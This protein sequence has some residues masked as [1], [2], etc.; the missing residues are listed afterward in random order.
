MKLDR[1][2]IRK[3]LTSYLN[4]IKS[5]EAPTSPNDILEFMYLLKRKPLS[6]GPYPCVSLFETANR[7]FSDLV[8]LFGV[9][10]LLTKPVVGNI[11]LPFKE[12]EVALGVEGG[13]DLK[14][15]SGSHY[16]IGEAFNASESLFP[17]KIKDSIEKLQKNN[18]RRVEYRLIIFNSDA[19]GDNAKDY[20]E[21]TKQS[22]LYLPVDVPKTLREMRRLI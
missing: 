16:L 17:K 21:K 1:T 10:Q 11:R 9:K 22:V 15:V 12:Y 13:N 6:S 3:E 4:S 5:I 2:N 7:I 20:L 19:V 14:A 8:I 18:K